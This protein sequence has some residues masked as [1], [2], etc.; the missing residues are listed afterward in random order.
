M[1]LQAP[2]FVHPDPQALG[3]DEMEAEITKG[4]AA[5]YANQKTARQVVQDIVPQVNGIIAANKR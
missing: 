4:L 2:E 3:W 1:F 5:L